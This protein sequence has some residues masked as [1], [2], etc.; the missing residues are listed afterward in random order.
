M[1]ARWAAWPSAVSGPD[2]MVA[3]IPTRRIV[4]TAVLFAVALVCIG[5]ASATHSVIPVF[6]AWIPLLAVPWTLTRPEPGTE[7]GTEAP[8]NGQEDEP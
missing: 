2:R 3:V 7:A 6:V 1:E 4:W 8:A 5:I